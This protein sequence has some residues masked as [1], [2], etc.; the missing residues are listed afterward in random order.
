MQYTLSEC[1]LVGIIFS[2]SVTVNIAFDRYTCQKTASMVVVYAIVLQWPQD[3]LLYLGAPTTTTTTSVSMLGYSGPGVFHWTPGTGGKG[4]YI[5]F[6]R[7]SIRDLPSTWAWVLK[8]EHIAWSIRTEAL[9]YLLTTA[10]DQTAFVYAHFYV[11]QLNWCY[12]W[13]FVRLELFCFIRCVIVV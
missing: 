1:F 4:V 3:D 6:P 12:W 8:L 10:A 5:Q 9:C 2:I 13:A 7:I 11:I